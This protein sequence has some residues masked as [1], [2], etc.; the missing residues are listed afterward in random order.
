MPIGLDKYENFDCPFCRFFC[1]LKVIIN[2]LGCSKIEFC[3]LPAHLHT[4]EFKSLSECVVISLHF[5]S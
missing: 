1:I 3:S 5:P 4:V 2:F